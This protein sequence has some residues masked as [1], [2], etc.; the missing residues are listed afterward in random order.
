M[1]K[2]SNF[3]KDD[4]IQDDTI[5][6]D[7]VQDDTIQDETIQEDTQKP[8]HIVILDSSD[9]YTYNIPLCLLSPCTVIPSTTPLSSIISLNPDAIIIGPG[10]G[11]VMVPSDVGSLH[12]VLDHFCGDYLFSLNGGDQGFTVPTFHLD[13]GG[14]TGPNRP[15]GS[16]GYHD[17]YHYMGSG[18]RYSGD[19][20]DVVD[21]GTRSSWSGEARGEF[22]GGLVG[23]FS[24]EYGRRC[25]DGD[26]GDAGDGGRWMEVEEW[27][28]FDK[29]EGKGWA[30]GG[31]EGAGRLLEDLK[32]ETD[33]DGGEDANWRLSK[34]KEEYI[35]DIVSAK[36]LITTGNTYEI[37]LTNELRRSLP[38]G[39]KAAD[40]YECL[41]RINPA[42][43]GAY[44]DFGDLQVCC[45]SPERFLRIKE[46][47]KMESKP[48]KGTRKRSADPV[49]DE[50]A[51]GDLV[52]S[53][54]DRA[55]NLMI[56]DLVRADFGRSC[57]RESVAV[58]KFIAVESYATV[59]QL[60]STIRGEIK[61]GSRTSD[62]IKGCYPGG[63]MTGAPKKRTMGY[64][65]EFEGRDR[66]V[67]SG[68]IGWV[69]RGEVDLNI[70][71]RTAVVEGG[72]VKIGCGGAITVKSEEVEEWEEAMV[73]GNV[74]RKAVE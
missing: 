35:A 6:D 62:A 57:R 18:R 59:H 39:V 25:F 32:E 7:T 43:Y 28:V 16:G 38:E 29:L 63:S 52:S 49:K 70:C 22:G 3:I 36:E 72:E 54:K 64:I 69:S 15:D 60:V 21:S 27:F 4:T 9:S 14:P 58:P 71:I 41:R 61:E 11:S 8:L 1:T 2:G 24:Y 12:S 26:G 74:V 53:S 20:S 68:S 66:G 55:E 50:E 40:I 10:P 46:G 73:K 23:Y 34:S 67:Y 31:G 65:R 13:S 19:A 42:P 44:M 47:G 17:R 48:I 56:V 33:F 45:S 5:Q 30:C 37:C 51:R